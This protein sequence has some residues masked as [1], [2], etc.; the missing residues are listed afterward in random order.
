MDK[1]NHLPFPINKADDLLHWCMKTGMP[2][3]EVVMEN[4]NAWRPEKETREGLLKIWQVM[5]ECIY[6]GCHTQGILPGGLDVKRR[7]SDLNKKLLAE[8]TIFRL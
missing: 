3:S 5:K 2:I 1:R 8:R 6:R 7:A 4:E